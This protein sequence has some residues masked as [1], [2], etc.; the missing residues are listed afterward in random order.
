MKKLMLPTST[1][2]PGRESAWPPVATAPDFRRHPSSR[3]LTGRPLMASA[4]RHLE[5]R[6]RDPGRA[7][8]A[9]TDRDAADDYRLSHPALA[10]AAP[11]F[12]AGQDLIESFGIPKSG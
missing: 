5:Y 4:L 10:F 2:G 1:M 7:E 8:I 3:Y 12:R 9:R 11:A 6:R